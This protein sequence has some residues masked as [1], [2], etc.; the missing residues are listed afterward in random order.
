MC[1]VSVKKSL[2]FAGFFEHEVTSQNVKVEEVYTNPEAPA[3][4]DMIDLEVMMVTG[5]VTVTGVNDKITN[6]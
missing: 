5:A 1:C 6:R 2:I 4:R 3:P